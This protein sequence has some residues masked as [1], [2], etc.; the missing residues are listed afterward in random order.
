MWPKVRVRIFDTAANSTV[1]AISAL[2]RTIHAG[3]WD[4]GN[5]KKRRPQRTRFSFSLRSSLLCVVRFVR[6]ARCLG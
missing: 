4:F 6:I 1:P 3:R 2:A 5:A